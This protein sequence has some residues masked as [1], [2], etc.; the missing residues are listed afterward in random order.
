MKL[1]IN[2]E[3]LVKAKKDAAL[4]CRKYG[5]TSRQ[6]RE[7]K[8]KVLRIK[9]AAVEA[10][11]AARIEK[12]VSSSVRGCCHT[13]VLDGQARRAGVA[14]CRTYLASPTA[15]IIVKA[16]S[17]SKLRKGVASLLERRA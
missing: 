17:E 13:L 14:L 10:T 12:C 8:N 3:V 9:Q 1:A 7:A 2:A 15:T 5:K 16:S 4:N 11:C 6:C